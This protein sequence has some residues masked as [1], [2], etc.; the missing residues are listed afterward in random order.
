MT[1]GD[2]ALVEWRQSAAGLH[3]RPSF[4]QSMRARIALG[5]MA[6]LVMAAWLA[7]HSYHGLVHDSILY[8]LMAL[9]RLHPD[10]LS[11]DVFLRFGSQD[12]Y[13]LFSPLFASVIRLL[14]LEPAA[15]LLTF[16]SHCALFGCAFVLARRLMPVSQALLATGLLVALPS[17]YGS[18]SFFHYTED[19][20]TPRLPA[21]ALVLG[22]L[23]ATFAQRYLWTTVFSACAL[24]LHPVMGL[25]GVALLACT[26][27]AIPRPRLALCWGAMA[28]AISLVMCLLNV[29][30]FVRFGSGDERW[31]GIVEATSP[32]LFLS[33]WSV[34]DWTRL[35]VPCAALMF[36]A[37]TGTTTAQR[38]LCLGALLTAFAGLA[39]TAIYC[40]GLKVIPA[41]EAQ[42]WRWLWVAQAVAVLMLP[43]IGRDCWRS[44]SIGRAAL[45]LLASAWMLQD[46]AA[47]LLS[48]ALAMICVLARNAPAAGRYGKLAL[49]GAC[50]L[51]AI[52]TAINLGDKYSLT[53]LSGIVDPATSAIGRWQAIWNSDGVVTVVAL[54]IAW[55]AL[56]G[57]T[58]PT[59]ALWLAALGGVLCATLGVRAWAG[60]TT[61]YYLPA[62]HTL[63]AKWRN[64][65]S[66][67]A[68]VLWPGNPVGLWYLLERQSYWSIYQA[69]GAVFSKQKALELHRRTLVLQGPAASA[70][71]VSKP[72][73][74]ADSNLGIP[75]GDPVITDR[76]GLLR[77][78]KSSDLDYVVSWT[79]I[80]PTRLD[81]VTPNPLAPHKHMYLFACADF[82]G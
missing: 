27:W 2:P 5:A 46:P 73:S 18:A 80:A 76:P 59:R 61:Y 8:T 54:V 49:T 40:D 20:L 57:T 74:N 38:K 17:T 9:A 55:V 25:A 81:P 30:P 1:S 52:A 37:L 56:E 67:D 23:A 32:Y 41:I 11:H 36:G 31:L 45:I 34:A 53:D 7:G 72:S 48:T 51:L 75:G 47:R 43:W 29:A 35:S 42:P 71:A 66:P 64:E 39:L 65:M 12:E 28:I 70:T 60:W 69:V 33:L 62:R 26:F 4:L 19:F 24:L 13:T 68:E 10:S 78:C 6:S 22:A 14:D 44:G 79:R 16:L 82:R 15:A 3:A 21:E 63:F 77:V 50:A 58:T